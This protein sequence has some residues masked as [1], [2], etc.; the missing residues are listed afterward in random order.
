MIRMH[1][2]GYH[3]QRNFASRSPV[4]ARAGQI[5]FFYTGVPDTVYNRK[6]QLGHNFEEIV[7]MWNPTMLLPKMYL[8]N[9]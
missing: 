1:I 8:E 7:R 5:I 4:G 9:K 6:Y 2:F 3:Q